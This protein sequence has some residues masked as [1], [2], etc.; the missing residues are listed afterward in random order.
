MNVDQ[1]EGTGR[2]LKYQ[3]G[4]MKDGR[5]RDK[6]RSQERQTTALKKK[7]KRSDREGRKVWIPE[8]GAASPLQGANQR[9]QPP[10][11]C[12]G[13]LDVDSHLLHHAEMAQF[14]LP[15]TTFLF[16]KFTLA[17]HLACKDTNQHSQTLLQRDALQ[18]SKNQDK[19]R[20]I[21]QP[22][23]ISHIYGP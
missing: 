15:V 21:G 8:P 14:S 23:I 12:C 1:D 22:V 19:I 11:P 5:K 7:R 3:L 2:V 20:N 4:R 16:R 18:S 6:E 17:Q 10:T 13:G 9:A